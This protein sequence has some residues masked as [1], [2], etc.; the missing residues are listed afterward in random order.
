MSAS[1]GKGPNVVVVGAGVAG[2]SA[3]MHAARLG[4]RVTILE[5]RTLSAGSSGLS[6]GI[7]NRQ[8]FD[9]VDLAIRVESGRQFAEMEKET[10]FR[11]T[12]AGYVRL[13]R[14]QE[15]WDLVQRTIRDGDFPDTTLLDPDEVAD[16]VPG[17]RLDDV[18]G[19]MYGSRDGYA[20]GPELCAAFL[21]VARR[22]GASFR[23][24]VE[25][26]SSAQ[27]PGGVNLITSDGQ[28]RADVVINAAGPWLTEVG[29]RLGVS[30]PLSN[31]LH[32]IALLSVP[33][34]ANVNVPTVQTY[35]PGSGEKAVYVRPEGAGRFIAGLHSYETHGEEADPNAPAG[36][37]SEDHLEELVE[38]LADRFPG[39]EDAGIE[40]GWSGIYPLS[41]DG[42]FIIGPT[43]ENARVIALGG[44]GGVGLT[45]SPAVGQLAAEW[46]VLGEARLFGFAD[47]LLPSRFGGQS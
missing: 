34:L 7:F 12:R 11:I 21:E 1:D 46:A 13:A 14:S 2:L 23:A 42:K 44:L 15:Q 39:W 33:S 38:H 35:F 3:A 8:T 28:L 29:Q 43:A 17:M 20:D 27:T 10:S 36:R 37:A 9:P 41:P 47:Q 19:A 16:L 18:V 6:A 4:A 30:L 24:G 22:R 45:V 5:Q 31:R 26:L 32:E 25:V 40:A